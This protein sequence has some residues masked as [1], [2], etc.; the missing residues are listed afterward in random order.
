MA[1]AKKR[2]SVPLTQ[3]QYQK[4][5]EVQGALKDSWNLDL[6]KADTIRYLIESYHKQIFT[7][8]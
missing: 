6:S 8:D 5:N 3:N 1:E 4:L 7:N 2:V